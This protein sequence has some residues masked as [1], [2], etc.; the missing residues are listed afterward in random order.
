VEA[1]EFYRRE[2]VLEALFLQVE[3]REVWVRWGEEPGPRP[4]E[5]RS[6]EEL[7]ELIF[8]GADKGL[9]KVYRSVEAFR[10]VS[11]L[12]E[13]DPRELRKGWDYVIDIDS[14]DLEGAKGLAS[15]L[16]E[17]LEFYGVRPRVKFSGRRGF[18]IIVSGMAFDVFSQED[19]IRAYEILPQQITRFLL[20]AVRSEVRRLAKVDMQIYTPRRLLRC[21][22]SLHDSGLVSI[23]VYD[24]KAFKLEDAEPQNVGEVDLG[25]V[26]YRNEFREGARLLEAL[27]LWLQDR[28]KP[29]KMFPRRRGGVKGARNEI[30]W[31]EKLMERPVDDG[32][33]RL[34]WL[35]IAPYLV[36]VKKLGLEEAYEE[37][38]RYFQK[39]DR[40][41][42]LRRRF[43]REIKYYLQYAARR[44]LR[45]L[46][47]RSLRERPEYRELW[48]IVSRAL[49]GA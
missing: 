4:C 18:H 16:V 45:P 22:Y 5:V 49:E 21:A 11:K 33:H 32:R 46:S 9:V 38:W 47:I 15:A 42:R 13:C 6:L 20:Q 23:P 37:A 30:K 41:R 44:G 28:E 12:G 26:C 7:R 27:R 48:R 24:L 17:A 8:R 43:D 40:V 3:E 2:E 25:W 10:D 1:N 14:D 36:N 29:T 39:C 31:I 19:Y 35:V 34:L